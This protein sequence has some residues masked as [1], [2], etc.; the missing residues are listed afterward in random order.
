M[1]N[2]EGATLD[3][4]GE[5]PMPVPMPSLSAIYREAR[6]G[7]PAAQLL[8]AALRRLRQDVE[9]SDEEPYRLLCA[10]VREVFGTH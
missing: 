8:C 9:D 7:V 3:K 2:S 1:V 10:D 4:R 5:K 6:N